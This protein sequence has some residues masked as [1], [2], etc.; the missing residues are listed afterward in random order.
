MKESLGKKILVIDDSEFIRSFCVDLLG[1]SGFDVLEA[2]TGTK[3]IELY[4]KNKITCVILDV[5]LPDIDGLEVLKQLK[6]INE[7]V[8]IVLTT[9]ED[10]GWVV[11]A[12]E[13]L[14][15]HAFFSK[16]SGADKLLDLVEELIIEWESD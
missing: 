7:D 13:D 2:E 1:D 16:A 6:K 4:K 14:G 10:P 5:M 11:K 9:G 3:G 15:A 8:P 12:F